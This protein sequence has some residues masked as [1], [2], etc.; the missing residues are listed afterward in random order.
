MEQKERISICPS[1]HHAAFVLC[2]MSDMTCTSHPLQPVMNSWAQLCTAK[3]VTSKSTW[4]KISS[5]TFTSLIKVT[6]SSQA[7]TTP[8]VSNLPWRRLQ[9]HFQKIGGNRLVLQF[10][11][12]S[13]FQAQIILLQ[14]VSSTH[15]YT[16]GDPLSYH[17]LYYHGLWPNVEQ[18]LFRGPR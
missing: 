10:Q 1:L 18:S 16:S 5:A 14:Y 17:L 6:N 3:S 2:S 12:A 15:R 7:L 8:P 9:L 11:S 4:L 13:T